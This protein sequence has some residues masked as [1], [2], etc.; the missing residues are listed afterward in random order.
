MTLVG[1]D[2]EKHGRCR[3]NVAKETYHSFHA[4]YQLTKG[5]KFTETF[6]QECVFMQYK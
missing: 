4:G 6:N 1:R 5:S 2:V 3:Y